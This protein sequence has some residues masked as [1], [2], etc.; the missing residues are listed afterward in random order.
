[1]YYLAGRDSKFRPIL[2]LDVKK[3]INLNLPEE[4]IY[5]CEVYFFEFIIRNLLIPGHV[6]M[7]NT[8]IDV[9]YEGVM[10]MMSPMKNSI[11]F[12]QSTFRSRMYVAY[13]VRP[14]GTCAFMWS[15]AQRFLQ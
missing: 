7:W 5:Q 9:G 6:E 14:S 10:S 11:S 13:I 8:I 12:L 2:V 1:V 15:I 3:M 4:E